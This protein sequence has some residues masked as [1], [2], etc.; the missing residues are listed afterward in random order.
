MSGF[1]AWNAVVIERMSVSEYPACFMNSAR[2]VPLPLPE[3][4]ALPPDPPTPQALSRAARPTPP[5]AAR[6]VRR[7]TGA[8]EGTGLA[9]EDKRGM[10]T[11]L[12]GSLLYFR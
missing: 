7:E 2:M 12:L 8:A 11:P 4:P 1:A 9:G 5:P 10:T 3:A 6:T